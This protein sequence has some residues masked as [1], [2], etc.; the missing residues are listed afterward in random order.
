MALPVLQ[1]S[2]RSEVWRQ[3][4]RQ[5]HQLDI[6]T[7]LRLQPAARVNAVE[8][9]VDVDLQEN[10][11]MVA[12]PSGCCRHCALEAEIHQIKGVDESVDHANRIILADK[13]LKMIG[14]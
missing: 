5:P 9:P 3:P 11:R 10:R 13:I 7:R 8:I 1:V 12:R 2:D 4:P 14:E 6:A